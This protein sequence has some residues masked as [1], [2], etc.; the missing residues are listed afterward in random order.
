MNLWRPL[1]KLLNLGGFTSLL[2]LIGFTPYF[3]HAT[4]DL[5]NSDTSALTA[6]HAYVFPNPVRKKATPVLHIEG[7]DIDKITTQIYD[8]TGEIIFQVRLDAKMETTSGENKILEQPLEESKFESGVY[9]GRVSAYS[10]GVEVAQT[11]F[12]FTVIQ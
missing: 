8:I 9:I 5:P 6:L 10:G 2:I 11:L 3:S 7:E 1:K 4:I 12:H